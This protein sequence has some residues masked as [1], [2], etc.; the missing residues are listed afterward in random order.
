MRNWASFASSLGAIYPRRVECELTGIKEPC[1]L[2]VALYHLVSLHC[3]LD[4]NDVNLL[5]NWPLWAPSQLKKK[6]HTQLC[7][8][9]VVM[10]SADIPESHKALFLYSQ[11]NNLED[12]LWK[13]WVLGLTRHQWRPT[14]DVYC[15]T[16]CWTRARSKGR[17]GSLAIT[18]VLPPPRLP[19]DKVL[20]S[21][22]SNA[23]R[24]WRGRRLFSH[25]LCEI[26]TLSSWLRSW[27]GSQGLTILLL[28]AWWPS[29]SSH[30]VE[31]E[32]EF[33]KGPRFPFTI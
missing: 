4:N 33:G 21:T 11:I 9:H 16:S 15:H 10:Q 17:G 26:N 6:T 19:E 23:D 29:S 13:T 24:A 5:S 1:C 20:P 30:G 28:V 7:F 2:V 25:K 22:E 8:F 14:L 12:W 31:G 18:I 27:P 3:L 32:L